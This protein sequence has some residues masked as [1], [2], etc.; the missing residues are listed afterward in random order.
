MEVSAKD[1]SNVELG[2]VIL[3]AQIMS[4]QTDNS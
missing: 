3:L 1:N 2:F 4:A